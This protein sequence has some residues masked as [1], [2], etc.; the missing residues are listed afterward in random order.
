MLVTDGVLK[1]DVPCVQA[2]AS[3]RI[4]ARSAVFEVAAN[5]GKAGCE[6]AADLVM[7][8]GVQLDFNESITFGY[9]YFAIFQNSLFCAI[10]FARVSEG[11]VLLF[12][13]G[14]P[15]GQQRRLRR[16]GCLHVGRR[17]DGVI[18]L[19]Y[20]SGTEHFVQ[21]GEGLARTGKDNDTAYGPVEPVDNAEKNGAGLGVFF[22]DI[23]FYGFAQWFVTGLVALH[24]F[25]G[26]LVDDDDVV[27]FVEYVHFFKGGFGI[28]AGAVPES[29][30]RFP[31]GCRRFL[32]KMDV[33]GVET[34]Y[35]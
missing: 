20:L 25:A 34:A 23:G 32:W 7:A 35:G 31:A 21:P 19:A 13:A 11:A 1:L 8:A 9:S 3:V 17:Q 30:C 6:L 2:D 28:L 10:Y 22:L 24:N 27:V 14:E 29:G 18:G 15:V 26:G 12:V 4:A 33:R 5:G 16:A